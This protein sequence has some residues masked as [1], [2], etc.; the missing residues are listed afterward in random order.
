MA[1]ALTIDIKESFE[2][3]SR[4]KAKQPQHLKARVQMLIILK[5]E[6]P[7]S[8]LKLADALSVNQN[9]AQDWRKA[10]QTKG[11]E[12]LLLYER[13]GNKPSIIS[14]TAHKSIEKRLNNPIGAFRSYIELQ[15]WISERFAP[16]IKY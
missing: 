2:E 16:G 8:K 3:L 7:L 4:F 10:Y 5:R 6:G 11:M 12:G 14:A 13:G 9:T 1:K 15:Q